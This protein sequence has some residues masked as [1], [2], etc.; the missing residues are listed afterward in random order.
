MPTVTVF[1]VLLLLVG[2]YPSKPKGAFESYTPPAPPNYESLDAWASHPAKLDSADRVP[3]MSLSNNQAQAEADVFFIHPTTYTGK[4]GQNQWNGPVDDLELN[5]KTDKGAIR[6]Q[7]SVFN[8]CYR[9]FAPRYRQAHYQSYFTDDKQE[10]EKAFRLA[11]S[12]VRKAFIHYLKYYN[13]GRPIVIAGHSQGSTHAEWL[14]QDF[15][16]GKKLNQQLVAAYIPGMPIARR[17][18]DQILPCEEKGDIHCVCSWRTYKHGYVPKWH[19]DTLSSQLIITN[20]L[21]WKTDD[22]R[23]ES[24]EN[25]GSVLLNFYDGLE[26]GVAGAEIYGG[27]LWTE[28]PNF[29]GSFFLTTKNYHQGDFNLY[30]KSIRMNACLRLSKYLEEKEGL[31]KS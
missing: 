27:L 24:S 15:F 28:K 7:A 14:L 3:D 11:Y 5:I 10:A 19:H 4:R 2:C 23:I 1:F 8:G 12:D 18:M 17:D 22:S 31:K 26:E 25:P 29:K 30:Y 16:N 6:N 21:S 20:P 13:Q 9:I